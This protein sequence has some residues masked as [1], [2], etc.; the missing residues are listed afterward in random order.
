MSIEVALRELHAFARSIRKSKVSN[1]KHVRRAPSRGG[2]VWWTTPG[3]LRY[4]GGGRL[5][6]I[7]IVP[8]HIGWSSWLR[9]V[10]RIEENPVN[11]R[12][13]PLPMTVSGAP[14]WDATYRMEELLTDSWDD[15]T[16][17][18]LQFRFFTK[19]EHMQTVYHKSNSDLEFPLEPTYVSTF[20]QMPDYRLWD[21]VDGIETEP[22]FN[23]FDRMLLEKY[24]TAQI[25][26]C[27]YN[28]RTFKHETPPAT[29]F[30]T[31]QVYML[32]EQKAIVSV[33][34]GYEQT[35]RI[36]SMSPVKLDIE[37]IWLAAIDECAHLVKS[38][39]HEQPMFNIIVRETSGYSLREFKV[40]ELNDADFITDNYNDDFL[41]VSEHIVTCLKERTKGITLLYGEP[42]TGKTNFIRFLANRV[43]NKTII[44]IPPELTSALADPSFISFIMDNAKS[45]FIVEDA[46]NVI[47]TRE[48]GGSNAVANILNM[49]D[50]IIGDAVQ[51]Q[52]VCTFNCKYEE[53]DS[54]L[55]RKGRLN[56][57][58]KFTKLDPEKA[59]KLAT[60]LYGEGV[61]VDKPMS[62]AEVYNMD[63][64]DYNFNIIQQ[65]SIGFAP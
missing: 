45:I 37:D 20:G 7:S 62:L 41:E 42:G 43:K 59:T 28:A 49:S 13:L 12:M 63:T 35:M 58:H 23:T 46:E 24:P 50:G 16:C 18:S 15:P 22:L 1:K 2:R 47:R 52:F 4:S 55:K 36:V 65:R 32:V 26:K 29:A 30:F 25:K 10:Q 11:S 31:E 8:G 48:A 39:N 34:T 51:C 38:P 61:T 53:V 14:N 60:K 3:A 5:K 19:D 57:S 17:H 56:A 64:P 21:V 44:Y 40:A 6:D 54:A 33:L 27:N 9:D